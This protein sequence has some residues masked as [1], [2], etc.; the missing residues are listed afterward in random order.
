VTLAT[1]DWAQDP[2]AGWAGTRDWLRQVAIRDLF[3]S[4]SSTGMPYGIGGG[5]PAV[6]YPL[7][8]GN[9]GG[10]LTQRGNNL[11]SALANLPSLNLPSLPLTASL[12][13]LYV[14]F[15]G[16][17][18]YFLLK[19]VGRRELAWF[20]I[21]AIAIAFSAGAYGIG[22]GT[23]GQSVQG[24]QISIIHVW[25]ASQTAYRETYTGLVTPTHGDYSVTVSGGQPALASIGYFSNGPV[26]SSGL[27]RIY[28]GQQRL[29]LL[30]VT[31]FTLRGFAGEDLVPAPE[32]T[33]S[34]NLSQ[35]RV[36]GDVRNGSSIRFQDAV[37]I[38][39]NSYQSLGPI[40]PGADARVNLVIQPPSQFGGPGVAYGIYPNNT[41]GNV[42]ASTSSQAL[43]L[44]N[45]RTQV[46]QLITGSFNGAPS[47][48]TAPTLVAWFS[49]P[50]QPSR[51][52][53]TQVP[54]QAENA[55]VLPVAT[56]SYGKGA[57]PAGMVTGRLVD[58]S[59]T[60]SPNG[61]SVSV[62]GGSVTYE[63]TVP[64]APGLRLLNPSLSDTGPAVGKPYIPV[65]P[66]ALPGSSTTPLQAEAWNWSQQ[67]WQPIGSPEPGPAALPVGSY[68]AATG[69]IRIRL[70][71]VAGS[72]FNIGTLSLGGTLQ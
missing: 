23:R 33:A 43:R 21:P 49:G 35:G 48:G 12:I 66:S 41:Y 60:V 62:V 57:L 1:F 68:N 15:V 55:V 7:G 69:M 17:L 42:P 8:G 59:G 51:V 27:T 10:S 61:I 46:L 19:A 18:N 71:S 13:L 28:P 54:L 50:V 29:D 39:G 31:A 2:V 44:G 20:T 63:F 34:V 36:T 26:P 6:F 30:D 11:M 4:S 72:S 3:G 45:E 56:S 67:E 25:P 24:T 65:P 5:A 47:I 40:S 64:S 16:P 52:N 53:G 32:L 38:A 14:I 22:V 37:V 9:T 70:S 58:A